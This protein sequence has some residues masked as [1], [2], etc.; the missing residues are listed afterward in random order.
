[1][2]VKQS[3]WTYFAIG[4]LLVGWFGLVLGLGFLNASVVDFLYLF[5]F[6]KDWKEVETLT[7]ILACSA[8]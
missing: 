7:G 2:K 5:M 3:G 6:Q 4:F 8:V 1:M